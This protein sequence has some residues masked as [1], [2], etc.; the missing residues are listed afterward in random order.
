ME[1]QNGVP[2]NT[3]VRDSERHRKR[4]WNMQPVFM[5]I[6]CEETGMR[7]KKLIRENGYSVK[8]I[9]EA[10]GFENPQAVYKWLRGESLPSIDNLLILGKILNTKLENILAINGGDVVILRHIIL[11]RRFNDTGYGAC[12]AF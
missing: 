8:D 5:S 6:D 3:H 1:K 10:M 9:Q 7:I 11:N 4:R 12:Y 2:Y